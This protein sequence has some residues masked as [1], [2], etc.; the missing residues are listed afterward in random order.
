MRTNR[1]SHIVAL[2]VIISALVAVAGCS[3][4]DNGNG[5][6]TAPAAAGAPAAGARRTGRVRA[7]R[8]GGE[9]AAAAARMVPTA[10]STTA[11]RGDRSARCTRRRP[12]ASGSRSAASCRCRPTPSRGRRTACSSRRAA[13]PPA[14][15]TASTRRV[16]RSRSAA[17][18]GGGT[19]PCS[20]SDRDGKLVGEWPHLEKMFAQ[21]PCGRG[22]HK[23][24][25]NPYDA[26]KHVWIID[27]QQ[28]VIWKFT[29]DGKVVLTLGTVGQ[30]RARCR[31]AV[32]PADRHRLA[33]RRHVLH[34]RRLR[35]HARR[36]VR[37]GRQVHH[38][39]GHAAEGSDQSGA[40]RVEYRSQHRHQQGP[41]ALRRRPRAPAIPDLRRERQVP[42]HVLDRRQL[43]ALLPLHLDRSGT[44]GWATAGR[45]GFSSTTSTAITCTAGAGAADSAARSTARIS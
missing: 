36:Q 44:C 21:D 25:M 41:A 30:A 37:Q 12:I 22:P 11:G 2:A 4:P 43:V 10:S 35:R 29:N 5:E 40:E 15:P 3:S 34:Q 24:K 13:T 14:M 9:L 17:G 32:R 38:G 20:S 6:E 8:A 31:R 45:T 26:E 42:R 28:H 7:L 33:A 18:S 1:S 19:I 27:D 23:I 16:N 39:L